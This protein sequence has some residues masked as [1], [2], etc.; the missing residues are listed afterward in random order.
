MLGNIINFSD[1]SKNSYYFSFAILIITIILLI[2]LIIMNLKKYPVRQNPAPN[3]SLD[4]KFPY[5]KQLLR[6]RK[7]ALKSR[8][9]LAFA[10]TRSAM[11]AKV[12]YLYALFM[13]LHKFSFAEIGFLF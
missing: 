7:D 11:W 6:H 1:P 3:S 9:L 12:P 13:I 4:N 8:Y 10:I 5:D 2:Q